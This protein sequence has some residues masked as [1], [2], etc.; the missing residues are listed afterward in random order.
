MPSSR[1]A[2]FTLLCVLG[3]LSVLA[4]SSVAQTVNDGNQTVP[5]FGSFAGS[6]F[7]LIS[8]QNGNVHLHIPLGSWKQRGGKVLT[9]AFVYDSPTWT[10]QTRIQISGGHKYFITSLSRSPSGWK[11]STDWGGWQV[12][13]LPSGTEWCSANQAYTNYYGNWAVTDP[14]GG[15]HPV[16]LFWRVCPNFPNTTESR[17]SD[18]SGMMVN[19]G[20]NPP[21]LILKD[22]T[23]VTLSGSGSNYVGFTMEDTNGN[24]VGTPTRSTETL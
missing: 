8:L 2:L 21:I 1:P 10:K 9:A 14:E 20:S 17:S 6:N 13:S 3:F 11:L 23:K 19:I 24:L 4:S 16:D 7:D 22:G 5:P 15:R 12:F 18:G